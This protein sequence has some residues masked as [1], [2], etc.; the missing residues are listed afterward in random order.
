MELPEKAGST[1]IA[2]RKGDNAEMEC[3]RLIARVVKDL[4]T[5]E[6]EICG[7]LTFR[8][9]IELQDV[10]IFAVRFVEDE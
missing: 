10:D 2:E 6:R 7:D 5:T 8:L 1:R 9:L 3:K 4:F